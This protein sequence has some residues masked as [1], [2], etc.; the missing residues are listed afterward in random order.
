LPGRAEIPRMFVPQTSIRFPRLLLQTKP[1]QSINKRGINEL[2]AGV[3]SQYKVSELRSMNRAHQE[4]VARDSLSAAVTFVLCLLALSLAAIGI[5]AVLSYTVQLRQFEMGIRMAIGATPLQ[6]LLQ[7]FKDNLKP[8]LMGLLSATLVL[9]AIN[10]LLAQTK[11]TLP[12]ASLGWWLP[13][14]LILC[15]TAATSLLS[16]WHLISKPANHILRG[17]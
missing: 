10:L 7:I 8:V 9:I 12:T 2:M 5:Y 13:P 3:N 6:I 15:L 17:E 11:F 1:N 4:L 14:L 16:V